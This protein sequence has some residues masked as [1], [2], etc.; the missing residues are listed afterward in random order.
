MA[1]TRSTFSGWRGSVFGDS[2]D[3]QENGSTIDGADPQSGR[4]SER[5]YGKL[6]LHKQG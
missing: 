6:V 2:L 1:R 4:M 5:E 3:R